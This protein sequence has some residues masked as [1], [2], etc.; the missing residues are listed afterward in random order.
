MTSRLRSFSSR[1]LGALALCLGGSTAGLLTLSCEELT[2]VDLLT[3]EGSAGA[4]SQSGGSAGKDPAGGRSGGGSGGR[5]TGGV[6]GQGGEPSGGTGGSESEED[7]GLALSAPAIVRVRQGEKVRV[8]LRVER[9]GRLQGELTVSAIDLP[10]GIVAD[11]V[12]VLEE[13]GEE[14]EFELA[15]KASAEQTHRRTLHLRVT[16][17]DGLEDE[18]K[19]RLVVAGPP[20]SLDKSFGGGG[21]VKVSSTLTGVTVASDESIWAAGNQ[22]SGPVRVYHF[23]HDGTPNW[24]VETRARYSRSLGSEGERVFVRFSG[25]DEENG[26]YLMAFALEGTVDETFGNK[27]TLLLG[28]NMQNADLPIQLLPD[29]SGLAMNTERTV[30]FGPDGSDLSG[31]KFFYEPPTIMDRVTASAFDSKGR[32]WVSWRTNDSQRYFVQRARADGR[33]DTSFGESGVVQSL[34]GVPSEAVAQT[35]ETQRIVVRPDDSAILF[36]TSSPNV[37]RI[38]IFENEVALLSFSSNG[39][40]DEEFGIDGKVIVGNSFT[41]LS[42]FRSTAGDI[43]VGYIPGYTGEPRLVRYDDRGERDEQFGEDGE[44]NLA[45]LFPMGETL[46]QY[47]D[48]AHESATGRVIVVISS[49]A[50]AYL[51]SY[52]L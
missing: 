22:G 14:V 9:K 37:Q 25:L 50:S 47:P 10:S 34:S 45:H 52:W 11:P 39:E 7:P 43:I 13:D 31:F 18:V 27:G 3:C 35:M 12:T 48:F 33:L 26:D 28:L 15:A 20:G 23:E 24:N 51:A 49:S 30:R 2:C 16:G 19:V 8:P 6:G 44:I 46:A 40:L 21:F 1:L 29:G 4:P 36:A 32:I 5:S 17:P 41:A 42:A 38:D